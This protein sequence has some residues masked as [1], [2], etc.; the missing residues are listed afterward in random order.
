[1]SEEPLAFS[2]GVENL[3]MTKRM[4]GMTQF[5]VTGKKEK[6]GVYYSALSV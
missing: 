1:V 6:N 2:P 3:G 4:P 5:G